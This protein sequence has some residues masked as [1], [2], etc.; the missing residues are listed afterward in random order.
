L[1]SN[2]FLFILAKC[3]TCQAM[4][5]NTSNPIVRMNSNK[6]T[7]STRSTF[8]EYETDAIVPV[9]ESNPVLQQS[10]SVPVS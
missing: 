5:T 1:F 4:A 9:S 6:R 3:E 2:H 10:K 7:R 8:D